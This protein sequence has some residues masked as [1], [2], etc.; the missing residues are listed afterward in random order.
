M[1]STNQDRSDPDGTGRQRHKANAL[2]LRKRVPKTLLSFKRDW[3]Y[4]A[5]DPPVGGK[6][7]LSSARLSRA[8]FEGAE[9][10]SANGPEAWDDV[11]PDV[12][13]GVVV[14][15]ACDPPPARRACHWRMVIT[16]QMPMPAKSGSEP[17]STIH[18]LSLK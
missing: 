16:D 13:V 2:A 9:V 17:G 3:F 14:L 4:A 10:C 11:G 5:L 12:C 7:R 15:N 8:L 1:G 6:W 18:A